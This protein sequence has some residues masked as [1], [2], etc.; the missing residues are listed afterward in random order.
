MNPSGRIRILWVNDYPMLREGMAAGPGRQQRMLLVEETSPG[1]EAVEQFRT[2][3]PD[4][5]LMHM[6]MPQ[7]NG[8][9]AI[10]KT[11]EEFPDAR[12][13][14]LTTYTGAAQPTR[15]F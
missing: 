14:V 7:V 6:Q 10:P 9:D 13:S 2:P 3:Q 12:I 8:I 5:T 11:R 4:V 15:A 1:R